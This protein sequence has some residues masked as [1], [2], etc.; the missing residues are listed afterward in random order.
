MKN[1]KKFVAAL[2]VSATLL[3]GFAAVPAFALTSQDQ[4]PQSARTSLA[5]SDLWTRGLY[6]G[7][8]GYYF[9]YSYYFNGVY[10][11]R[12][13]AKFNGETKGLSAYAGSTSSPETSSY[14]TISGYSV[15]CFLGF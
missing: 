4:S 11:H 7:N 6:N 14:N 3:S 5:G 12:S 2:C 10:N 8:N 9:A 1:I 15:S 13:E